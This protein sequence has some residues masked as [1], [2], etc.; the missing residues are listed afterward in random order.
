M[1]LKYDFDIVKVSPGID[2]TQVVTSDESVGAQVYAV[3]RDIRT[4]DALR[5]TSPR[6]RRIFV[7]AGFSLETRNNGAEHG[8]Y[9]AEDTADREAILRNLFEN[10]RNRG[11]QGQ[12]CGEFDILQFLKHVR[13]SKPRSA[14]TEIKRQKRQ[15]PEE[16]TIEKPTRRTV[17]G[18]IGFALGLAVILFALLKFLAAYGATH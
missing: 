7:D 17:V 8:V 11:V 13:L 2:E 18:R 12:Y 1:V 5:G 16:K 6:V 9:L 14:M 4:A 10:I 3:F 15:K